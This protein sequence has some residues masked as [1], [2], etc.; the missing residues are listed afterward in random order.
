MFN[1]A[2]AIASMRHEADIVKHLVGK[3]DA[4]HMSY[5]P[6]DGQRT[7]LELL[8]YVT[9]GPLIATKNLQ[10]MNW[11][12]APGLSEQSQK[13]DLAGFNAAMDAQMDAI[14]ECISDLDDAA[15]AA[16]ECTMPWG[17]SCTG[18]EALVNMG[19]KTLVAY[20]MQLF[21]YLK[22][23][24]VELRTHNCWLGQDPPAQ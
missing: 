4:E 19:L 14:E 6:T 9:C 5:Q 24:G 11:D 20:R 2:N 12:H 18:G 21:L 10:T 22:S 13:V 1:K 15:L 16:K 8:Q 23:C 7:L 17:V 3:A